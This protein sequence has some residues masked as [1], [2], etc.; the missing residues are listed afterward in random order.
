MRG[1][2]QAPISAWIAALGLAILTLT[3][4]GLSMDRGPS[5][6]V[7]EL[8]EAV[9]RDDREAAYQLF[10]AT[11]DANAAIAIINDLRVYSQAGARVSVVNIRTRGNLGIVDVVYESPVYGVSAFRFA[12][13]RGEGDWKINAA[14]SWSLTRKLRALP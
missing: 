13:I 4:F 10:Q 7:R 6:I 12:L 9:N 11:G 1:R 14:E 3:V 2:F 8:H 5:A